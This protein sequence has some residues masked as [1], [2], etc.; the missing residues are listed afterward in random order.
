VSDV[1]GR[2]GNPEAARDDDWA[3]L[4]RVAAGD[5]DA[6]AP[7]VDRHRARVARLCERF[8]GDREEALDAAQEVFLRAFRHA[9]RAEPRG[10]LSTWLH[11]IA[12]NLCLNRLRRRRLVRFLALTPAGPGAVEELPTL[13]PADA[14]ADPERARG[15][16]GRST[17]CRRI[18]G[19]S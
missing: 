12:V 4:A 5:L 6:F 1:A 7:L 10:A 2:S 18:N 17:R 19:S 13:E 16:D 8:L 9:G 14:G 15:P 11:R 3:A